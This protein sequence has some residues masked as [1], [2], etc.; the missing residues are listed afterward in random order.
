[1]LDKAKETALFIIKSAVFLY[2]SDCIN[3]IASMLTI[4]IL[5]FD[6]FWISS[7]LI[8]FIDSIYSQFIYIVFSYFTAKKLGIIKFIDKS[9]IWAVIIILLIYELT[10]TLSLPI[11]ISNE[12]TSLYLAHEWKRII[13]NTLS[14]IK[15]GFGFIYTFLSYKV[16]RFL[17][18][19]Y[20]KL[21]FLK[22]FYFL[23]KLENIITFE[24][25]KNKIKCIFSKFINWWKKN[26]RMW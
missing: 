11:N 17:T 12:P 24:N 15:L 14:S 21:S 7:K 22:N 9:P 8:P 2:I 10:L 13:L 20:P 23:K 26:Y 3:T 25:I 1:M 5:A 6:F 16:V 18:N 4:Q 19:K